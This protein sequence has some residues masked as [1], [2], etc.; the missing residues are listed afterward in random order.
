MLGGRLAHVT[1]SQS[2]ELP[3][4]IQLP[5]LPGPP[6]LASRSA[7]VPPLLRASLGLPLPPNTRAASRARARRRAIIM[8]RAAAVRSGNGGVLRN[9]MCARVVLQ[10]SMERCVQIRNSNAMGCCH[11]CQRELFFSSDL[12]VVATRRNGVWGGVAGV[13]GR[14]ESRGVL[15]ESVCGKHLKYVFS[16]IWVPSTLLL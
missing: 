2:A 4:D 7:P 1:A 15:S 9:L 12:Q 11:M 14:A 6:F 10:G 13:V 8:R 16:Q 3:L 5:P